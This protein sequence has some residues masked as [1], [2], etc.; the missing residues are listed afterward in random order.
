MLEIEHSEQC[1][2]S[3]GAEVIGKGN[4]RNQRGIVVDY[5][6]CILQ[7][8]KGDIHTDAHG[9]RLLQRDRDDIEQCLPHIGQ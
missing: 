8:D 5:N 7:T 4:Q 2:D 9:H 6:A 1:T 3:G